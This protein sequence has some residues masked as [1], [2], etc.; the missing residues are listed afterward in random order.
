[1]TNKK[2]LN[3]KELD[4]VSGGDYGRQWDIEQFRQDYSTGNTVPTDSAETDGAQFKPA[5]AG[6]D[7]A[8]MTIKIK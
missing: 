3:Q 7:S 1:M 8:F 5:N 6:T 4:K 2:D